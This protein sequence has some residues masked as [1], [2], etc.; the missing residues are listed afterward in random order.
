MCVVAAVVFIAAAAAAAASDV[1]VDAVRSST[2]ASNVLHGG[3]DPLDQSKGRA[4]PRVLRPA[5]SDEV[6]H[7]AADADGDA[8]APLFEY[9]SG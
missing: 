1:L 3:Q 8:R 6:L 7:G 5:G 2:A 9:H 4:Q